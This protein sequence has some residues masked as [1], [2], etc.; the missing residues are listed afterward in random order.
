MRGNRR[1]RAANPAYRPW[2]SR[3]L[4]RPKRA[5]SRSAPAGRPARNRSIFLGRQVELPLPQQPV[6]ESQ[7]VGDPS[8]GRGCRRSPARPLRA[9]AARRRLRLL[10]EAVVTQHRPEDGGQRQ[11]LPSP[12]ARPLAFARRPSDGPDGAAPPTGASRPTREPTP[13]TIDTRPAFSII[14]AP[15]SLDRTIRALIPTAP[16]ETPAGATAPTLIPGVFIGPQ[17]GLLP[18]QSRAPLFPSRLR[19]QSR[20]PTGPSRQKKIALPTGLRAKSM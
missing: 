17:G 13:T 9:W 8:A 2:S 12:T 7:R 4:A 10:A 15:R 11:D 3:A 18:V 20:P 16:D 1:R 6:G 19:S 14:R 5:S